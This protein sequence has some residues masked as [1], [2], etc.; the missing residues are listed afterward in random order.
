M[1]DLDNPRVFF[2]INIGGEPV[3]RIVMSLFADAVPRTSENFRALCTGEKGVSNRGIRLH[4]K[5][6]SFHRVIPDFMC[7][8]GDIERSDGTGGD[9]IYG[10]QFEDEFHP[11]LKHDQPY[12]LASANSGPN[13]N[14]SQFYI[15]TVPTP[16][17]DNKHTGIDV[18][19]NYIII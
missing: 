6:C 19:I 16:W 13:T 1:D 17:L 7:Q 2:D 18:Y 3:G 4:Y 11:A 5:G 9:S 15:T 8:S 10:R 14:G 12:T